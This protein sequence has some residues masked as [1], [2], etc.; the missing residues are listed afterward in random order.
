MDRIKK[1]IGEGTGKL[2]YTYFDNS[3]DSKHNEFDYRMLMNNEKKGDET[4]KYEVDRY[5]NRYQRLYLTLKRRKASKKYICSVI[6][7]EEHMKNMDATERAGRFETF[8]YHCI[9]EI[10]E[11]FT[12]KN[13]FF[14]ENLAVNY[15]IDM[16]YMQ[17][18]FITSS[19][20]ILWK[21]FGHIILDNLQKNVT[22]NIVIK[23]RPRKAYKKAVKGDAILDKKITEKMECRHIDIT[24]SDLSFITDSLE[25]YKNGNPHSNDMELLYV[26]FCLYKE[27][28]ENNKLKD[29]YFVITKRK[30]ITS[31]DDR[32]KKKKKQKIRFNMNKIMEI[33]GAKSYVGSFKRFRNT[34][35]I[36]IIEDEEK[37]Q[38]RIK[39]DI[40]NV[41]E[42][43]LFTVRNIYNSMIYLQAYL[44]NKDI[45][46]C[47]VCGKDFIKTSNNQKTCGKACSD[48]LQRLNVAKRN[49]KNRK[50]EVKEQKVI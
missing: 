21:C 11:I 18:E 40:P 8:H 34:N 16:E 39:I 4:A 46:V 25:L 49:E 29:G 3:Y 5:D 27:A 13:G 15:L 48:L 10:K 7:K 26:L 2:D 6:D 23:F 32:S 17:H 45:C 33:A 42:Q 50:T 44:Q 22:G 31:Y 38:Y 35:G 19:K 1:Y 30:H 47:K 12:D 43:C 14:N 41:E 20:D 37:E 24:Q 36:E 28:K 9:Q